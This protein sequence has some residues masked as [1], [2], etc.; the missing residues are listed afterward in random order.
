MLSQGRAGGGVDGWRHACLGLDQHRRSQFILQYLG[1]IKLA[2]GRMTLP[3]LHSLW[4][5]GPRNL[6]LDGF[7]AATGLAISGILTFGRGDEQGSAVF[8]S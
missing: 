4:Q 1:E 3:V 8:A 7:N 6:H 2:R 5:S